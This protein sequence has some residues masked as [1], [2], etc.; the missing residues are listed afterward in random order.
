MRKIVATLA[1]FIA[2]VPIDAVSAKTITEEQK[3][4]ISANCSSIKFR[5]QKVQKD[6]PKSRVHIGAQYEALSTGLMMNLNLR[7]VKNNLADANIASQ[8]SDFVAERDKFKNNFVSYSQSLDE[9]I[10]VDCRTEPEKFYEKLEK[11]REK[12]GAINEN[13][14]RIN[15]IIKEHRESV[16]KLKEKVNE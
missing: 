11:V 13:I 7:L 5:L 4:I 14:S 16:V 6:G 9:L 10:N 3:G 2:L 15:K 12:R 8:Q 1:V